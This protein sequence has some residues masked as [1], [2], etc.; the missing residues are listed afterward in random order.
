[1]EQRDPHGTADS[2]RETDGVKE[3][4]KNADSLIHAEIARLAVNYPWPI[5][6]SLVAGSRVR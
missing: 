1:M 2:E 5:R 3:H 6:C 4:A